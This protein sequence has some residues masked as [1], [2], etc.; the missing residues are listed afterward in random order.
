V[1]V[2][3]LRGSETMSERHELGV[4]Q[5]YNWQVRITVGGIDWTSPGCETRAEAEAL[6]S[7][8]KDQSDVD[9]AEVERL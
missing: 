2:R 4:T 3:Q 6:K 1:A 8:V 5:G 7:I 9:S